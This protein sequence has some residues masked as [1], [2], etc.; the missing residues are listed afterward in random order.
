MYA[1][2]AHALLLVARLGE[3]LSLGSVLRIPRFGDYHRDFH[4]IQLQ[5]LSYLKCSLIEISEISDKFKDENAQFT[6]Q[7]PA[8]T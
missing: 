4:R 5:L 7:D 1:L 8:F 3:C 6:E 2:S